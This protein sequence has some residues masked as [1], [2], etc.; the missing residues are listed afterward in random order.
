MHEMH[1]NSVQTKIA[2]KHLKELS[3]C[4]TVKRMLEDQFFPVLFSRKK[5]VSPKFEMKPKTVSRWLKLQS[6]FIEPTKV[7]SSFLGKRYSYLDEL[8]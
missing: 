2:S 8:E 5:E 1:E 4:H 3:I 6:F 7:E